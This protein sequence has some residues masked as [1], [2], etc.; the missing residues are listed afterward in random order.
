[1]SVACRL[2]FEGLEVVLDS[3]FERSTHR[4]GRVS[5]I[6]PDVLEALRVYV[7]KYELGDFESSAIACC[8]TDSVSVKKHGRKKGGDAQYTAIILT[9]VLLLWATTWMGDI[10]VAWARLSEIEVSNYVESPDYDLIPDSG[11]DIFGFI[12]GGPERGSA[13]VGLGLEPAAEEFRIT[14][15]EAVVKAGGRWKRPSPL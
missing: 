3:P 4:C 11:V 10:T 5:D 9:P 8:V 1:M 13:F 12:K 14:L 7:E 15:G 6:R 2:A